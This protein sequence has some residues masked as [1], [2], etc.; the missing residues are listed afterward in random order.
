MRNNKLFLA[1]FLAIILPIY[2]LSAQSAGLLTSDEAY[3]KI[4]VLPAYSGVKYN[5]IPVK[6]SLKK[7]CPVAGDQRRT[8]TCVC[9]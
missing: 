4:P 7:Y 2:W 5:E 8:G 9:H 3:R 6:V 1:L